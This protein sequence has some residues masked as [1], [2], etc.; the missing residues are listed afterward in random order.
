MRPNPNW[1]TRLIYRLQ[2]RDPVAEYYAW[3][4][5]FGRVAEGWILDAQTDES[6]MTIFYQ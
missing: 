3:L 6:G 4:S 5:K 1:F 2:D